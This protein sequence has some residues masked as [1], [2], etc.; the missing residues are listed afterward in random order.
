MDEKSSLPLLRLGL[1]SLA[2]QIRSGP[3]TPRFALRVFHLESSA[4][5][6]P[7]QIDIHSNHD[8]RFGEHFPVHLFQLQLPGVHYFQHRVTA[9]RMSQDYRLY[10]SDVSGLSGGFVRQLVRQLCPM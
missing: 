10:L 4:E 7:L 6:A 3:K 8:R 2:W 9:R 5:L 1:G